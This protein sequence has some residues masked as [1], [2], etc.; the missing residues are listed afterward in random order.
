MKN[1]LQKIEYGYIDENE[2][3]SRFKYFSMKNVADIINKKGFGRTKL[4]AILREK[5]YVNENN[6]ALEQYVENGYFE[7]QQTRRNLGGIHVFTNQVLVTIKG[8]EL[9]K[10]IMNEY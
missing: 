8:L 4:Y 5:N 6:V 1:N 10:K 2:C 9:I 3:T 7:N